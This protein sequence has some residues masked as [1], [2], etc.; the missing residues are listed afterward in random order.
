[1]FLG[2]GVPLLFI[3]GRMAALLL[4]IFTLVFCIYGLISNIRGDTCSLSAD[5]I[6]SLFVRMSLANKIFD[7]ASINIQNFLLVVFI[8]LYIPFL[9]LLIYLVRKTD[10][11]AD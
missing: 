6:V 2:P 9:Q 10:Q 4:L 7:A 3:F 8:F 5:C 11:R 1:M